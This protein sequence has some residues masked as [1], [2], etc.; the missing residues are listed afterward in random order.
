MLSLCFELST[1]PW[2]CFQGVD[3]YLHVF[4]T[5]GEWL[6][7]HP[8]C[9]APRER[10][11]GTDHP[12]SNTWGR[13]QITELL[14]MQ[15]PSHLHLATLSLPGPNTLLSTLLS[16]TLNI[17]FS[18]KLRNQVSEPYKTTCKLYFFIFYFVRL[19]L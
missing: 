2:R 15:P 9:F 4:L 10:A 18:L 7:P 17:C 3:V 13:A 12:N 5:L 6:A 16:N 14:S 8:S 19:S 1:T 11:P